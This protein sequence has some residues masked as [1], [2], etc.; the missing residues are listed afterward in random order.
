[1]A[2]R[3]LG[4][5]FRFRRK[6]LNFL[7]YL[8]DKRSDRSKSWMVGL[9]VRLVP[10]YAWH[11]IEGAKTHGHPVDGNRGTDRICDREWSIPPLRREIVSH[12]GKWFKIWW[13]D[14]GV[15]ISR[16]RSS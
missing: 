4:L 9:H 15:P 12:V 5:S 6:G 7:N 10:P 1:M 3:P 14:F 8:I 13:T 16:F 11:L 2:L